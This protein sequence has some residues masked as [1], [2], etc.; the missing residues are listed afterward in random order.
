M[1]A[2]NYEFA[3]VTECLNQGLLRIRAG[4]THLL[5]GKA[6]ARKLRRCCRCDV[7]IEPRDTMWRPITNGLTRMDRLCGACIRDIDRVPGFPVTPPPPKPP[8][9]QP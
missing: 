1:I 9:E 6:Q 8:R 2:P 5:W 4:A 7:E 3:R